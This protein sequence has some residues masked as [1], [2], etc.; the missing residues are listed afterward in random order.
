MATRTL[1]PKKNP[2][3]TNVRSG[4]KVNNGLLNNILVVV[5]YP[6]AIGTTTGRVIKAKMENVEYLWHEVKTAKGTGYVREDAFSPVKNNQETQA[7]PKTAR[8]ALAR[9]QAADT[10]AQVQTLGQQISRISL[11]YKALSATNKK[12]FEALTARY[13]KLITGLKQVDGLEVKTGGGVSGLGFLPAIPIVV[14][15]VVIGGG[16][17]VFSVDRAL[18][19]FTVM[20]QAEAEAK[21]QKQVA[22]ILE[23]ATTSSD[24]TVAKAAVVALDKIAK[25]SEQTQQQQAKAVESGDLFT[26]AKKVLLIGGAAFIGLEVLKIVR[27]K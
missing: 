8:L 7:D 24:P 14:Y 5:R 10:L 4:A 27:S 23:K 12:T 1:Y 25:R 26:Q 15:M 2:G 22:D 19:W 20:Q 18:K 13:L 16:F 9:Q 17:A 6:A 21:Q 3:F 11:K